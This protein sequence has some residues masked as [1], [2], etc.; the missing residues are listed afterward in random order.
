MTSILA[1]ILTLLFK[2]CSRS[3][4]LGTVNFGNSV[5]FAHLRHKSPQTLGS[6]SIK[7]APQVTDSQNKKALYAVWL[8]DTLL[9]LTIKQ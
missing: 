9:T 1:M 8:I 7:S 5:Q 4:G 3:A 6:F 2:K